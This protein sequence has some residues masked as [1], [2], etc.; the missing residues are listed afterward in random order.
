MSPIRPV[1]L[2]L[3]LVLL[4]CVGCSEKIRAVQRPEKIVSLREVVYDKPT[5]QKLATL[6]KEYY[7]AYP[8]EDAYA[9]WMYATRYAG[10]KEYESL[11]AEGVEKYPANPTL[12]YLKSMT[13]HG[14]AD[15]LE[16][17]TLLERAVELDPS[18]MDPWFG[19]L[20]HYL[21]RGDMEK[22]DV[23]L[24]RILESGVIGNEVM[25]YSYNM[26]ACLDKDAILITNGDNDTFPGWILMRIIGYRPDVRIVNR[27]LLNTDWYPFLLVK[28]NVPTFVTK[29]SHDS[30]L[31]SF[32]RKM[33]EAKGKVWTAGPF[34][35]VLVERLVDACRNAGRPVYMAATVME[36]DV[37]K[38]L[39][40]QGREL[41]TVILVTPPTEDDRTQ[42]RG[43]LKTWL[44]KFRTSGMDSWEVRHAKE[45]RAG[46]MLVLNYAGALH[47]QMDRIMKYAPD[48][49]LDL[50]KWYRDHMMPLV[51]D[52]RLDEMNRMWCRSDDIG[53]IREWCRSKNLLK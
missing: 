40:E 44:E 48:Y 36:S 13:K 5:Y 42:L 15:D 19:L 52:S 20:T 2:P 4:W 28:D 43:V 26:L 35:D 17:L 10:A 25:D 9:N 1:F 37:I 49:R 29:Q 33:K 12:L 50:F 24:R 27:S 45:A 3:L 6:W 53:E 34:G 8:S 38:R 31:A 30:L 21:Q 14:K 47:S 51:P 32:G 41:G 18:Y 46:R 23:A 22:L 7:D 16:G 39:W 11:L